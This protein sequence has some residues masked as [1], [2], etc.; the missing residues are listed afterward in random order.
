[1]EIYCLNKYKSNVH[2]TRCKSG[3]ELFSCVA[4]CAVK[5]YVYKNE[6]RLMTFTNERLYIP[7][8]YQLSC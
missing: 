5:G 2:P 8:V 3:F 1:M 4:K 6:A 7:K